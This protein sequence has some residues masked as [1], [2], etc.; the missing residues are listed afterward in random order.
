MSSNEEK[1]LGN[2][3]AVF[4]DDTQPDYQQHSFTKPPIDPDSKDL[5]NTGESDEI[6]AGK[7]SFEFL[8]SI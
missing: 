6:E 1:E 2:V 4:A 3:N 7:V 5:K 8:N